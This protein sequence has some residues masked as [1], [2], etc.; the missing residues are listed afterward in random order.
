MSRPYAKVN[1]ASTGLHILLLTDG[2]LEKSL[3]RVRVQG[4]KQ[5]GTKEL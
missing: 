3:Y 4:H 2:M 1:H 5:T